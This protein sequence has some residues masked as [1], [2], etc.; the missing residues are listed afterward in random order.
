ME[1]ATV[2]QAHYYVGVFHTKDAALRYE[3]YAYTFAA[4]A[5]LARINAD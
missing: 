2:V 3:N 4:G 1:V 5:R